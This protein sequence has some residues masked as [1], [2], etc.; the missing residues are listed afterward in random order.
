MNIFKFDS[1]VYSRKGQSTRVVAWKSFESNAYLYPAMREWLKM[2]HKNHGFAFDPYNNTTHKV[3]A[4]VELSNGKLAAWL[5]EDT[6][7]LK[8]IG[9]VKGVP[10]LTA[11]ATSA[12]AENVP[13]RSLDRNIRHFRESHDNIVVSWFIY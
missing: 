7:A 10:M 6:F 2:V 12:I 5:D 4:I 9:E 3:A 8:E 11:K 1:K 13:D